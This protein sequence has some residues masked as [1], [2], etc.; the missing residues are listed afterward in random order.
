[1]QFLLLQQVG[2]NGLRSPLLDEWL[3]CK[4]ETKNF[5][6]LDNNW[7]FGLSSHNLDHNRFNE[8]ALPYRFAERC[9]G[10]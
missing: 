7:S 3:A 5:L 9:C 8:A 1:M 10:K 6:L 4:T 2:G